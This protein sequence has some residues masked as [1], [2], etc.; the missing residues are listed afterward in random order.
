MAMIEIKD[1]N[2][3]SDDRDVQDKVLD[4]STTSKILGGYSSTN[5]A[6]RTPNFSNM[7]PVLLASLPSWFFS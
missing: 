3:V 7:N 2:S 6:V 5:D 1:L 4:S